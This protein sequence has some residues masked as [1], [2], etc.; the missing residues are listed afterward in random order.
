M[1][2]PQLAPEVFDRAIVAIAL[3]AGPEHQLAYRNEAF[4]ELFGP[5][6][7]G[8]PVGEL[9]AGPE[10]EGF[11]GRLDQV[12]ADGAARQ[13]TTPVVVD[14]ADGADRRYCVYSCSPVSS[15]YGPG[16]LIAVIDTTAQVRSTQD[17][18]RLS[19]ERL[20]ALER[21][22]ALMTAVSQ[23]VWVARPDGS[24]TELVPG[25]ERL[26][27]HPWRDTMDERWL[28]LVHPRDR[29]GLLAQ[30]SRAAEGEP[31]K[32]EYTYR[33]RFASG[34]YRHIAVR[35]VPVL[36][37][38]ELVEWVGATADVE[39]RWRTRQ[40]ERLLVET[41]AVTGSSRP[42]DAFEAVTQLVVP[43]LTDAC[44]VFL[45]A[46]RQSTG[47]PDQVI[48]TRIASAAR[49]GLPPLPALREQTF[50]LG[51]A[52]LR[53]VVEQTPV[54]I[55]FPAGEV[56][57]GV[58]PEESAHWL[59]EAHATSLTLLP[60]VIDGT[61]VVLAAAATCQD[62][63]PP[64]TGDI[65]LLR[66]VLQRAQ[67]ALGQ[68]LELQRTRQVALVL[69]R[70]L[71]TDPPAVP[72]ARITARYQPGNRAA[73]V[74]GDWYDAFLL[75]EG[76]VALTIGDVSGHDLTAAT[77]MGQLRAM[78]RSLAYNR[79]GTQ[80]PA[81]VLTALDRAAGGLGVGTFATAVHLHLTR[82]GPGWRAAWSNAGHPPPL[83][84][85]A[86]GEPRL[87]TAAEADVPLCVAPDE[88]RR[89]HHA[90]IAPG[91]TLLLYTDG[92]VE[93]PGEDLTTGFD[94]LLAAAYQARE[95]PLD[96]LCDLLLAQVP[97]TRDDIA[98]LA[99]RA[100]PPRP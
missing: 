18:E 37:G 1:P 32:F 2:E 84:L 12:L 51:P 6:P 88:P 71:L 30:W 64:G 23:L 68:T 70:A 86:T 92:L 90:D 9:F 50:R 43:D 39:D 5:R 42:E 41:T 16:V 56:P 94:R 63:P 100:L 7:L 55:T 73:E 31:S 89:T 59:A 58:V 29:E 82:T 45:L 65:E 74:G 75:P 78:L 87:L 57:S 28:E 96:D 21:Y 98:L 54:L 35:V 10:R 40:R 11:V 66:D 48:G 33:L 77:T 53:A 83:L 61:T 25:W 95:L 60:L 24:M 85:P 17:A 62:G 13:V 52:A 22:E 36:R 46:A 80:T 15:R 4:Q 69:Q 19:V 91:D 38:G 47:R 20:H 26:T 72:G 76:P 93:V 81:D 99:F 27:G 97:D 8:V 14:R 3:T 67:S 79:T 49:P 44:T 34:T